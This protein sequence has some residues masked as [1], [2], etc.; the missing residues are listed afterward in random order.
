MNLDDYFEHLQEEADEAVETAR[1]ARA[2]GADPIEDIEIE[3]AEDM[4]ERCEKLLGIDGLANRIRELEESDEVDGR[5]EAA[6][7][8]AE[9]FAEGDI[10][11]P[12]ASKEERIDSAVRTAV[13]LLTEG[14]VAAPIEGIANVTLETGD[15]GQEYIRL[16]YAG[17][18]RS[19]GGTGQA[20]SVL[21][22]DYIRQLMDIPEYEPRDD[23]VERT[24]E[25]LKVYDSDEGLQYMP[26]ED[27][28]RTIVDNLSIMLDA[29]A[30][31]TREM[32]AYRD[33]ER[34]DTNCARGGMC[35]TIGE[36]IAQKAPKLQRYTV[37]LGIDGWDWLSELK[38]GVD[39]PGSG[40]D[41][42]GD[43]EEGAE[44]D[45]SEDRLP[46]EPQNEIEPSKKYMADIIGG[47]PVFSYPSRPGGFRLRYGRTRNTSL[48]A[49]GCHPAT[50][51]VLNE[52]IAPATQLKTER[53]GKAQGMVPVDSVEGPMV[54]LYDGTVTRI[55]TE[56]EAYEVGD[57][58][59]EILDLGE[60]SVNYGEFLENNHPLAPASYVHEWWAQEA[61]E[62][63]L[64][65][66]D[67]ERLNPKQAFAMAESNDIPLHPKYTYLW[68]DLE[69]DEYYDL[70][71]EIEDTTR[72]DDGRLEVSTDI[73][74]QLEALLVPHVQ[75][76][77]YA[78]IDDPEATVLERCCDTDAAGDGIMEIVSDAAGVTVRKRAPTRIG[79]RMGRPEKSKPR[80]KPKF[81]ALFP[82]GELGGNERL[83]NEASRQ[84]KNRN[85]SIS[86]GKDRIPDG[87]RTNEDLPPG[88][89][90]E[91]IARRYCHE[92]AKV[93]YRP[94]CKDCGTRTAEHRHCPRCEIDDLGER[95]ECP[96]CE[97][98]TQRWST[99]P[100]DISEAYE[101]AL[102]TANLRSSEVGKIKGVKG[103]E[104]GSK[105]PEPLVKGALRAS[106]DINSFSDGTARY[107]LS[108]L[109]LTAFKPDE[110]GTDVETL[111]D[112]GYEED[113]HGEPLEDGEQVCEL[114][115]Q[116]VVVHDD[117]AEYMVRVANFVDDLLE[118][119][120][121][122][123]PYYN[124]D[125]VDDLIGEMLVGLA[126]HT[127]AGVM[128]RLIGTTEASAGYAHPFFHAAK[129]RNCDGDEDSF[130]LLLDGLINHSQEY[131]DHNRTGW[132][133]DMPIVLTT[134][135]DPT[136]ID[137]EA[138]NVDVVG[139]YP[140]EF[141]EATTKVVGPKEVDIDIAED[142]IDG[143]FTGFK[144]THET[145]SIHAGPNA[146]S[147][148][149][150]GDMD[151]KTEA[152]FDLA[153]RTRSI[154]AADVA[155]KVIDN[156]FLPDIRG[157][158]RAFAQQGARCHRCDI[159]YRRI[160]LSG[161]CR[162]CGGDLL[163]LVYEGSV[164]KYID[165]S[166]EMAN[167]YEVDEYIVQC[168]EVLKN[169]VD[170]IFSDDVSTQ[171]DLED[172]I[173]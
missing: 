44:T 96:K 148:T 118:H 114:M 140:L 155:E 164:D 15:S 69:P 80:E 71:E 75:E 88:Q 37:P 90:F 153:K 22:A 168:I 24:V 163:L 55:E 135:I 56:D 124:A 91:S 104:S 32:S 136:E 120:Y 20:L 1:Q 50:M 23:E 74:G 110:V 6:L 54:R 159:K 160:P 12:D 34:I 46:D 106:Y 49:S 151:A 157:N 166:L 142:Y 3:F 87:K 101:D 162:Q 119:E 30:A 127:S 158:L 170:S 35:L 63:G 8:L 41:S 99:R 102:E 18:I 29:D 86:G 4:A 171:T 27:E 129:R 111:H 57:Q 64:T 132:S 133:M 172:F 113:I 89:I 145:S 60:M 98:E 109:P 154:D 78:S 83:I 161:E 107:D 141:Y 97:R 152:Q 108:D 165:P 5:E 77:D 150:V 68:H 103:L 67:P 123:E 137:D 47:R 16:R 17:P 134:V 128:C 31:D 85:Q 95:E 139:E 14:V 149:W 25:E 7:K 156:H 53:P 130:M 51:V 42:D 82:I 147:Y 146:S 58:I 61:E 52:F 33:L 66:V 112:L 62:A 116:D 9:E 144:H 81:H 19:A 59:D 48:A 126:P 131:L 167:K 100:F 38:L 11:D 2:N 45:G 94:R 43:A 21:V 125:S 173:A 28:I 76:E 92:C 26:G 13:A 72:T 121:G 138:H 169:E 117:C 73:V 84:S 10:G 65:G 79:A 70:A 143:D 36:G 93:T 122:L 40:D 115:V 39:N 105:I